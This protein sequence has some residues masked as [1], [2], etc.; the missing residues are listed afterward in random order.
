MRAYWLDRFE[1]D[2]ERLE[3]GLIQAAGFVQPNSQRPLEAQVSSQLARQCSEKRDRDKRYAKAVADRGA[4]A[5]APPTKSKTMQ[6]LERHIE[7][8][9]AEAGHA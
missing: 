3:L 5:D 1:G 6:A 4:Q 9:R 8:Q 7:A 2:A